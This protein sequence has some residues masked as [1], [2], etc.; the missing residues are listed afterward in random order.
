[1]SNILNYWVGQAPLNPVGI[2][3]RDSSNSLKDCSV[4]DS[5]KAQLIGSDNEV[6]DLSEGSL[7]TAGARNG[8]FALTWPKR[9]VFTRTGVYVLQLVMTTADGYRDITSTAEIR[10]R[11]PRGGNR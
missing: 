8:Q 4:Y 10:V 6:V 3:V 5:F 11:D 2:Q 9:S 7:A 1:M